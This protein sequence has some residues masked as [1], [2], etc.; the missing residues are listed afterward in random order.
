MARRAVSSEI[1]FHPPPLS[2][3]HP[4]TCSPPAPRHCASASPVAPG[5]PPASSAPHARETAPSR[6]PPTENPPCTVPARAFAAE[7]LDPHVCA[8]VQQ[9]HAL[10]RFHRL[11]IMALRRV[12]HRKNRDLLPVAHFLNPK[13]TTAPANRRNICPRRRAR[14][15]CLDIKRLALCRAPLEMHRPRRARRDLATEAFGSAH[16]HACE[17]DEKDG[18]RYFHGM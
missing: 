12:P 3:P 8:C 9:L 11:R 17:T 1:V 16:G 15:P 10:L 14:D 18:R 4:M 6:R 2:L 7:A 5:A 13:I